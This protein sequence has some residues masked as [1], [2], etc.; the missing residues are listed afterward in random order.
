[1]HNAH[2]DRALYFTEQW[3]GAKSSFEG[4]LKWHIKNVIIG[5]LRN[6][7]RIALEWNVASDPQYNPHTPGGC[8]E[9]KGAITISGSTVTR[10]VAYYIIAHA[11]KFINPGSVRIGSNIP[12][13]LH[14]VAFKTPEGRK[15]LIVLN[16][17]SSAVSFN[18]R[19]SGKWA[20]TSLPAGTV[21]TYVW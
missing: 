8:T 15:V 11:S 14:N 9:C 10:N 21:A 12:G 18:I 3:T 5:S 7:S 19:F 13:D 20:V 2:P 6:W 17:G 4:D 1:V 16:D